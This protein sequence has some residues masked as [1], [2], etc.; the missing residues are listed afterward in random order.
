MCGWLA[1][2]EIGNFSPTHP[3]LKNEIRVSNEY[4]QPRATR[5]NKKVTIAASGACVCAH[6]WRSGWRFTLR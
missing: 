2:A 1:G 4:F 6:A 5:Q 3:A